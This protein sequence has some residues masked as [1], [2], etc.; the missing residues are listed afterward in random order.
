MHP[1]IVTKVVPLT[2]CTIWPKVLIRKNENYDNMF[3]G[4]TL[5][6]NFRT[7]LNPILGSESMDCGVQPNKYLQIFQKR[8]TARIW[9]FLNF[10]IYYLG[11]F[12][13][14]FRSISL[15][16]WKLEPF[17]RGWLE[18]F[19]LVTKR[20]HFLPYR[21]LTFCQKKFTKMQFCFASR[22]C[23]NFSWHI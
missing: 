22:I 7:L 6:K 3:L 2:T 21:Y 8:L 17:C 15:F 12:S 13:Q 5:I 1:T 10:N 20:Q 19:C 4:K 16:W 18:K 9:D 23:Y 11:P 14:N